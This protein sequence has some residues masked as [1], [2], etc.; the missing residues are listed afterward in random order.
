MEQET[1]IMPLT[2]RLHALMHISKRAYMQFIFFIR[3]ACLDHSPFHHSCSMRVRQKLIN[4]YSTSFPELM[5]ITN[6][7][8]DVNKLLKSDE[9]AQVVSFVSKF[10]NS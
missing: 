5:L 10:V 3:G 6:C 4:S 1:D 2:L 8:H 9:S 7:S